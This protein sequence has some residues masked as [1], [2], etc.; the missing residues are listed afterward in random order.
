MNENLEKQYADWLKNK[1]LPLDFPF[2]GE[3]SENDN[4]TKTYLRK[5]LID[6][7]C[8]KILSDTKIQVIFEKGNGCSTTFRY[9]SEILQDKAGIIAIP[10]E[11][12]NISNIN[13]LDDIREIFNRCIESKFPDQSIFMSQK[14]IQKSLSSQIVDAAKRL[15]ARLIFLVDVDYEMDDDRIIEFLGTIKFIR[16][17][18]P[19]PDRNL[20]TEVYFLTGNQSMILQ[21]NY[22]RSFN[23]LF[24]PKYS[25]E[26]YIEIL[27][28][29]YDKNYSEISQLF[30]EDFINTITQEFITLKDISNIVKMEIISMLSQNKDPLPEKFHGKKTNREIRLSELNNQIFANTGEYMGPT[31]FANRI[32]SRKMIVDELTKKDSQKIII[33]SDLLGAG[34]SYLI[35]MIRQALN[36]DH[37]KPIPIKT[38]SIDNVIHKSDPVFIDDIDIRTP[39][40]ISNSV[41]RKIGEVIQDIESPLVLIG[42]YT[43]MDKSLLSNISKFNIM[44]IELETLDTEFFNN[45]IS[46]R[47]NYYLGTMPYDIIDQEVLETIVPKTKKQIATFRT[48]LNLLQEFSRYCPDND[49]PFF[50]SKKEVTLWLNDPQRPKPYLLPNQVR[51]YSWFIDHIRCNFPSG[52]NMIPIDSEKFFDI[53]PD[54]I[55]PANSKILEEEI[56]IPLSRIGLLSSLGIPHIENKKFIRY[57]DP[58]LPSI[59]TLIKAQFG[60]DIV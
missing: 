7:A 57:P 24:F 30:R 22:P 9:I 55:K 33:I 12:N 47:M 41:L 26:E 37:S 15:N 25:I 46:M 21:S 42:D 48:V 38:F 19:A 27:K 14:D 49:E 16:E 51:F 17:Q 29:H 35:E 36:I 11:L 43:L 54:D 45:A 23:T 1:K 28:K 40:E 2:L 32:K 50:I 13:E 3:I 8:S 53:I 18:I 52:K 6:E 34:K 60:G 44:K 56:L 4:G 10:L 5:S 59:H 39:Y 20:L 31:I 58:Y